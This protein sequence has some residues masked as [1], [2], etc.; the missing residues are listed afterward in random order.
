M[1]SPPTFIAFSISPPPRERDTIEDGPPGQKS[2][3]K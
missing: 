2:N 1:L 3:S